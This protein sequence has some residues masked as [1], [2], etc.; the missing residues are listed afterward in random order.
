MTQLR[1][2]FLKTDDELFNVIEVHVEGSPKLPEP[3]CPSGSPKAAA[4]VQR[5]VPEHGSPEPFFRGRNTPGSGKGLSGNRLFYLKIIVS[6]PYRLFV[7]M[8]AII[9]RFLLKAFP[10]GESW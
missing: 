3:V 4:C 5:S 2:S 6:F 7:V 8:L 1:Q 9:S 10:V